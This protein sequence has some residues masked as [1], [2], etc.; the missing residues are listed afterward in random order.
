MSLAAFLSGGA[1]AQGRSHAEM[2]GWDDRTLE[3]R[4]DYIQWLFPLP[5]PSRAVPGSPVLTPDDRAAVRADP[6][7]QAAMTAAAARL[8][9]F[10]RDNDHWLVRF[11]H[12]HLRI[13]RIIRSLRL[14]LGDAAADAFRD[15]MM[16]RVEAA[17]SVVDASALA[18][19]RAA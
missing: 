4:H 6:A 7:A 8:F 18:H 12:N 16:A 15:A 9:A 17:G 19:W 1:D 5:E 10:Y 14:L 3:A 11:D 13:S 2:L